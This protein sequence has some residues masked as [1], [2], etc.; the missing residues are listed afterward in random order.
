[1]ATKVG[2]QPCGI[3]IDMDTKGLGAQNRV[4]RRLRLRTSLAE[5]AARWASWDQSAGNTFFIGIGT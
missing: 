2:S 5:K 1:M 3:S 4:E